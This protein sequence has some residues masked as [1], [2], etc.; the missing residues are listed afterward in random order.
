MTLLD[1]AHCGDSFFTI[2][3]AIINYCER[4]MLKDAH[5]I[6][7]IDAVLFNITLVFTKNPLG[8]SPKHLCFGYRSL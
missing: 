7:K 3:T 5:R 6:S 8:L 4:W 1:G 2:I